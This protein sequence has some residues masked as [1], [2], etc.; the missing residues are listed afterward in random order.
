MVWR[1]PVQEQDWICVDE[2]RHWQMPDPA[3]YATAER[4]GI[5][6]IVK[7][8]Q[9]VR[10]GQYDC[11]SDFNASY[12]DIG[13]WGHAF[14]KN[15]LGTWMVCGG[16]DFFN[17]GPTK[18]DLNAA[19]GINHI[20]FGM[21][22][23]NGSNAHIAAGEK[24]SKIYG[25]Y[26]LYCNSADSIETMWNDCPGAREKGKISS[27]PMPGSLACRSIRWLPHAGRSMGNWPS[28]MPS[29][30]SSL[31]PMPGSDLL[32]LSRTAIGSLNRNVTSTGHGPTPRALSPARG[33]CAS[34]FHP[35]R[36]HDRCRRRILEG[37]GDCSRGP[38]HVHGKPRLE[39]AAQRQ[40]NRLGDRHPRPQ[41]AGVRQRK[42]LFHGYG[43][44]AF[45]KQFSN[46]LEFTIGKSDWAKDWNYAQTG[47]GAESCSRGNG[48][49]IFI[50]IPHRPATR[51]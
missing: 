9:G 40:Q 29:S 30:H 18:Q 13:C 3:D 28:R 6:E 7:L 43:W 26:L 5:K 51:R 49:S 14:P 42:Q 39:R 44:D 31:P 23:Y 11:R 27:G 19:A 8:T 16:Y 24:W 34:K 35:L 38:N 12:Y 48:E 33:M 20:H 22:H 46:P 2:K 32:N 37:R 50:S 15:K 21:N 36:L 4:T 41:C 10:A 17:D 47:Y 25:P 45:P 1:T